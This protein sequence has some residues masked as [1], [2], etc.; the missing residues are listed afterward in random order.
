MFEWFQL[1][2]DGF[3]L[4]MIYDIFKFILGYF[5]AQWLYQG[6]Y[7]GYIYKDWTIELHDN[8]GIMATRQITP[9]WVERIFRDDYEFSIY[10]KS[11][12]SPYFFIGMDITSDKAKTLKLLVIDKENR[13]IFIDR[14]KNP[15]KSNLTTI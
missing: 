11:F 7:K 12:A 10:V 2:S 14:T 3:L 4:N 9:I 15:E 13:R 8:D 5:I 1:N 6:V